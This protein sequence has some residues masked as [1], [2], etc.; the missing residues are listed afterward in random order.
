MFT[1]TGTLN[2]VEQAFRINKEKFNKNSIAYKLGQA[3]LY[4]NKNP[5]QAIQ[6]VL[7]SKDSSKELSK[8]LKLVNQD[9]SGEALKGLKKCF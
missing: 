2:E 9:T 8:L 5:V 1:K 6:E 7:R 4:L 3:E